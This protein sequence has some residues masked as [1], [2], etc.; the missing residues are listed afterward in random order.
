MQHNVINNS[1]YAVHYG[2]L[3][4][5]WNTNAFH[6]RE[7]NSCVLLAGILRGH[8]LMTKWELF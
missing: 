6:F 3:E 8:V 5:D 7:L 1:H 4:S 2:F